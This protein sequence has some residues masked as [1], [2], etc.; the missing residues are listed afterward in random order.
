MTMSGP[1]R[2]SPWM[3]ALL[4]LLQPGLGQLYR[5]RWRAAGLFYG[6]WV[7]SCLAFVAGLSVSSP[8]W[9][10]IGCLIVVS[11]VLLLPV[12]IVEAALGARRMQEFH[13]LWFARWYSCLAVFLAVSL[14]ASLGTHVLRSRVA[15]FHVR[16]GTMIP[17]ILVGDY[18]VA[19]KPGGAAT[20]MRPCDVV[21]FRTPSRANEPEVDY[22]KRVVALPGDHVGYAGGRLRLN[23]QFVPREKVGSADNGTICRE[24]L[25][26]GCS[27]LILEIG[28]Q[29]PFDNVSDILVPPSSFFGLGDNRDDSLDSRGANVGPIPCENYRGRVM[30][31]Y[32]AKD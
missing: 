8:L 1:K 29:G 27:Y 32:G 28:D 6:L 10:S 3:A 7:I 20:S 11:S 12:S 2:R 4:P 24:T 19:Q 17:T 26:N 23:G 25:L 31:I 21:V 16:S 5:G 15:T 9:F 30:L 14:I 13:P 22:V 18:V